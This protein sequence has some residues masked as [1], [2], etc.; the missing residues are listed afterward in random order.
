MQSSVSSNRFRIESN[1]DL[2]NRRY[3]GNPVSTKDAQIHS[4]FSSISPVLHHLKR[5]HAA[6]SNATVLLVYSPPLYFFNR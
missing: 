6:V 5:L 1:V 3:S 2:F 4:T